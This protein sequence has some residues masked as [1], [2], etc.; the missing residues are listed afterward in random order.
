MVNKRVL[1][2]R[3]GN[4]AAEVRPADQV[5]TDLF[6]ESLR[7]MDNR[8]A[9]GREGMDL[10]GTIVCSSILDGLVGAS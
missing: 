6:L 7:K 4:G 3:C 1:E 9:A 5:E 8:S 2:D 10:L